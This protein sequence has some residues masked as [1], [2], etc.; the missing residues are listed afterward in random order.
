MELWSSTELLWDIF[1]YDDA[2]YLTNQKNFPTSFFFYVCDVRYVHGAEK[3]KETPTTPKIVAPVRGVKVIEEVKPI[4]CYLKLLT[5][6]ID[7]CVVNF[8]VEA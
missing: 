2:F 3:A 8:K 6:L 1:M 4:F 7:F 5:T